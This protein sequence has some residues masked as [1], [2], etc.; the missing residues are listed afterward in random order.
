VTTACIIGA[1]AG[2]GLALARSLA[3][4][5]Y[6]LCL[7][8]RDARDID[9]IANDLRIRYLVRVQ[10]AAVDICKVDPSDLVKSSCALS[11]HIDHLLVVAGISQ[12][13]DAPG[14]PD[15]ELASILDVNLVAPIR[16]INAF[17]PHLL[18]RPSASIT[19]AGSIA[20]IRARRNNIHY[21]AAKTGVEF[22]FNGL[23]HALS[24]SNCRIQFYRLGYLETQMTFG[25][26]LML[27]AANPE[28]TAADIVANMSIDTVGAYLPRW[29]RLPAVVLRCLPWA[30][31][32]RLNL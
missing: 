27:P 6:D 9:A 21:A 1:S 32:R 2:L 22:Y 12:K 26:E 11:G 16:I 10:T 28:H 3:K 31:Y 7:V 14:L 24:G 19:G 8:A 20:S 4:S 23:R 5:G 18:S 25:Q 13:N 17:I 29:W 30:I 15:A